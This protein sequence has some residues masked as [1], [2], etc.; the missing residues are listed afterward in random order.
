MKFDRPREL[1]G[2]TE[3]VIDG[4]ETGTVRVTHP[5]YL[6]LFNPALT[7]ASE[8]ADRIASSF[9]PQICV[10]SHAPA[11]VEI[12]LHVIRAVARRAGMP[13]PIWPG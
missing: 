2:L 3:W 11:A 6:G 1:A 9:N 8:C 12:E 4:L 10:H 5:G 13:D 7:F